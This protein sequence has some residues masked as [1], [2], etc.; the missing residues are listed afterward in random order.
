MII[1]TSIVLGLNSGT[2]SIQQCLRVLL[3][4]S[5]GEVPFRPGFGLSAED[6]LDGRA[7]NIDISY[8][9]IEQIERYEKRVKVRKVDVVDVSATHKRVVIHYTVIDEQISDELI[10][11][12]Q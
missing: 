12:L 7:R 2:K 3:T 9:V 6:L 8:A 10:I 1:M 11:E 5:K 4:T